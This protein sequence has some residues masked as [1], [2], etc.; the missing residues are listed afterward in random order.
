[1]CVHILVR[2][3]TYTHVCLSAPELV[4]LHLVVAA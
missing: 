3:N 1:M 4:N 2:V